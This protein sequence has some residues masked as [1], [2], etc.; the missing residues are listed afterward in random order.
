VSKDDLTAILEAGRWAASSYN[1]QPW[2]FIVATKQDPAAYQKLLSLLIPFN[3][4]WAK[5]APVLILTV[6]KKTFTN[7]QKPNRY[8]LH[9]AGAALA[10]MA[11]QA[12]E[13][14]LHIHGMGGFDYERART[15]LNIPEE[16]EI[17]AFAALGYSG[18]PDSLPESLAQMEVS[19]RQRKPLS[20]IAFTTSWE[21]PFPV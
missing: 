21:T 8:A 17:G 9:D 18:S 16:Y 12:T 1:E 5:S 10:N 6:A 15:E 2:R 19:P 14:G 4:D 11:L 7:N 13:L 20:E 3:Q